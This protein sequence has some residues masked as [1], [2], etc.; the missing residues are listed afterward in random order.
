MLLLL[1]CFSLAQCPCVSNPGVLGM[2]VAL[3]AQRVTLLGLRP[4]WVPGVS[5][6]IK[7]LVEDCWHQEPVKR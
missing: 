2:P 3:L 4:A 7:S 1:C 6:A 5:P